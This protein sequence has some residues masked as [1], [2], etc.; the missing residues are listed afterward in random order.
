MAG[1]PENHDASADRADEFSDSPVGQVSQP[2]LSQPPPCLDV[3]GVIHGNFDHRGEAEQ[4]RREHLKR[5]LR[6]GA[7]LLANLDIDKTIDPNRPRAV[8][9]DCQDEF[10]SDGNDNLEM[11]SLYIRVPEGS[12]EQACRLVLRVAPSDAERVH[13]FPSEATRP[14]VLGRGK[15]AQPHECR[16]GAVIHEYEYELPADR[17]RWSFQVEATTLAGDWRHTAPTGASFHQPYPY[18][19]YLPAAP[20]VA[21][22]PAPN[23]GPVYPQRL[24]GEVWFELLHYDQAGGLMSVRDVAVYTIAPWMMLSNL[25]RPE[26]VYICNDPIQKEEGEVVDVGNQ[27]TLGDVERAMRHLPG[28]ELVRVRPELFT[29]VI[30][31]EQVRDRWLQDEFEIGYCW[32]VHNWMHVAL[33]CLRGQGARHFV[34]NALP[35]PGMGLFD[36]LTYQVMSV[37]PDGTT[38]PLGGASD[39]RD[40]GGNLELSPPVPRATPEL[41][42]GRSGPRVAPQPVAPFGK[43]L[44]GWGADDSPNLYLQ[45]FLHA[46]KVQPLLPVD[47]SWLAV[48]HIDEIVTFVPARRGGG[49]FRMVM[50]H[51]PT[52][53]TAMREAL[54]LHE[55]DPQAHPL[56]GLC[57][58]RRLR[59]E[60]RGNYVPPASLEVDYYS[61]GSFLPNCDVTSTNAW[62]WRLAPIQQRL[63]DGLAL[64][65]G[66][67]DI[68]YLPVL[69]R[70]TGREGKLTSVLPNPVNMLVLN[71]HVLVPRPCGP[72]LKLADV[73]LILRRHLHLSSATEARLRSGHFTDRI[74]WARKGEPANRIARQFGV[75]PSTYSR[76]TGQQIIDRNRDKFDSQG[77]VGPDLAR[78]VIPENL[79]DILEAYTQIALEDIGLTVHWIETWYAYHLGE[80]EI[81]CGTNVKRRPSELDASPGFRYWW[82]VY[83]EMIQ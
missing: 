22:R 15:V 5:V 34:R 2:C 68:L 31:G 7:I 33:H 40:F 3:A 9:L 46:Q 77:V 27:D 30:D 44:M 56:T 57:R 17:G 53:L 78:L 29:D 26:T 10:V 47:V 80:G 38:E 49:N 73:S 21:Q 71:D 52:A 82:D 45:D 60:D 23:A 55:E 48:S 18:E 19:V 54:H 81:H 72:C 28:V 75:N 58:G 62:D 41:D 20:R 64:H 51:P 67:R 43:I 32:A 83:P 24:P 4:T 42:P 70:N 74:Y 76:V 65:P 12:G 61:V 69:F 66:G 50:A 25:H 14:V 37:H 13:V 63:R 39:T 16:A 36:S 79:V 11:A 8:Q 35:G 6:P 1:H 59:R